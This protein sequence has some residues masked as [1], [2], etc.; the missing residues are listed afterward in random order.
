MEQLTKGLALEELEA[1]SFARLLP[2]RIE[3]RSR[4][5][6][7][8]RPYSL[9]RRRARRRDNVVLKRMARSKH[10]RLGSAVYEVLWGEQGW[11]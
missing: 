5:K 8:R 6:K 9:T 11:E 10:P 7:R 4:R 2:D 3:M 1:H